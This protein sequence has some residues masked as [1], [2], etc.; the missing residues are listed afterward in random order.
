MSQVPFGYVTERGHLVPEPDE[1]SIIRRMKDLRTSGS[2]LR[3]I[4]AT[5]E[6]EGH[7]PKSGG[8]WHP[9]QVQRILAREE[10]LFTGGQDAKPKY[11]RGL[12]LS[13]EHADR[14]IREA[15]KT[16]DILS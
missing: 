11:K 10:S 8:H 7:S 14:M 16:M 13:K 6:E 12:G 5:L 9:S 4:A 2:S 1:Q 15:P 3:A